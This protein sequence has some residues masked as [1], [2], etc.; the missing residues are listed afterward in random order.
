ME[1]V[2]TSLQEIDHHYA[3]NYAD[4]RRILQQALDNMKQTATASDLQAVKSS[5][6]QL[7]TRVTAASAAS[8]KTAALLNTLT[9]RIQAFELVIATREAEEQKKT[10]T[11][12]TSDNDQLTEALQSL[13]GPGRLVGPIRRW[14]DQHP[15]HPQRTDAMFQLALAYV[16]QRHPALAALYLERIIKTSPMDPIAFE[17]KALLPTL[18]P[19]LPTS[20]HHVAKKAAT[21]TTIAPPRVVTPNAAQPHGA[22]ALTPQ[23]SESEGSQPCEDGDCKK[24]A[25][26]SLVPHNLEPD[27][28]PGVSSM[29]NAKT[30][31]SVRTNERQVSDKPA[32]KPG[33]GGSSSAGRQSA[34]PI[35]NGGIA[36][37]E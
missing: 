10:A 12:A 31:Q 7:E 25:R 32:A 29:R 20:R 30:N 5:V 22:D 19:S 6:S 28:S 4:T 33:I 1:K 23:R 15:D 17:A 14:I 2:T 37:E 27:A 11:A 9:T 24:S 16:D 26:P 13:Q 21:R 8:E 35:A 36:G 34:L 3:K 18:R